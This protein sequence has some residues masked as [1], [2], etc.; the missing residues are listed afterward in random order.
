VR[1]KESIFALLFDTE[2]PSKFLYYEKPPTL[3]SEQRCCVNQGRERVKC[4]CVEWEQEPAT[5]RQIWCGIALCL[6]T[7]F[8]ILLLHFW[9]IHSS[10]LWLC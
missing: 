4:F 9:S 1:P 8:W 2:F 10:F 7:L 5:N 3:F 6:I